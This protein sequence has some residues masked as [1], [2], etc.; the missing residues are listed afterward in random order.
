MDFCPSPLGPKAFVWATSTRLHQGWPIQ[1]IFR[2]SWG[3]TFA[4]FLPHTPSSN[5]HALVASLCSIGALE[6]KKFGYGDVD[7]IWGYKGIAAPEW[8]KGF[9]L[10]HIPV[11]H[12]YMRGRL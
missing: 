5:H 3:E 2:A 6:D 4:R 11:K 10:A 9:G 8:E 1:P 7:L 12:P